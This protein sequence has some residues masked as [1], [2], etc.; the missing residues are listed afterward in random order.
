MTRERPAASSA[1]RASGCATALYAFAASPSSRR[2]HII[3]CFSSWR[4]LSLNLRICTSIF[5]IRIMAATMEHRHVPVGI[6]PHAHRGS[7]CLVRLLAGSHLADALTDAPYAVD[8][9]DG[10][11]KCLPHAYIEGLLARVAE[12]TVD[13]RTNALAFGTSRLGVEKLIDLEQRLVANSVSFAQCATAT[14]IRRL[15]AE[16]ARAPSGEYQVSSS[17]YEDT[18]PF[19]GNEGANDTWLSRIQ[20]GELTDISGRLSVYGDLALLCGARSTIDSRLL[21]GGSRFAYSLVAVA[22]ATCVADVGLAAPAAIPHQPGVAAV[23]AVYGRGRG[24]RGRGRGPLLAAAIPAHAAVPAAP[25]PSS[26]AD[27]DILS[28]VADWLRT[29]SLPS[30]LVSLP[31]SIR[32]VRLE[33]QAR[34]A[35][36]D[37]SRR[38]TIVRSRFAS[39]LPCVPNLERIVAGATA[40]TQIEVAQQLAF[41]ICSTPLVPKSVS[42]FHALDDALQPFMFVLAQHGGVMSVDARVRAVVAAHEASAQRRRSAPT[43]SAAA[44]AT[45][46]GSSG[47]GGKGIPH[48][49]TKMN[50]DSMQEYISKHD[51]AFMQLVNT[52]ESSKHTL[53]PL[54]ANDSV[55]ILRVS[56]KPQWGVAFLQFNQSEVPHNA[57]MFRTVEP[58]RHK[59]YEYISNVVF[60]NADGGLDRVVEGDLLNHTFV[61][62]FL[63]GKNWDTA[64]YYKFLRTPEKLARR[65]VDKEFLDESWPSGVF[66]SKVLLRSLLRP[67]DQL[68]HAIGYRARSRTGLHGSLDLLVHYLET[69]DDK[70]DNPWEELYS[71]FQAFMRDAQGFHLSALKSTASAS[72]P[73]FRTDNPSWTARVNELTDSAMRR[74]TDDRRRGTYHKPPAAAGFNRNVNFGNVVNLADATPDFRRSILKDD[75]KRPASPTS[76]TGSQYWMPDGGSSLSPGVWGQKTKVGEWAPRVLKLDASTMVIAFPSK[77]GDQKWEYNVPLCRRWLKR[78]EG[79]DNKCLACAVVRHPGNR[80]AFCPYA[81]T[82]GHESEKSSAHTFTSEPWNEFGKYGAGYAKKLE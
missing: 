41:S 70:A 39:L 24:G 22:R 51:N 68:F 23:P 40:S 80:C 47:T 60:Q 10:S 72:F 35:F 31:L 44:V 56:Y 59:L 43:A 58:H 5:I 19:A 45:A 67:L 49:F 36:A 18:Q 13:V 65:V 15:A 2:S 53:S 14:M 54:A 77:R 3:A 32:D 1:P 76:S 7:E 57:L 21:S 25:F 30:E 34:Q 37:D 8:P 4:T 82:P 17:D 62:E 27:N 48:A 26:A 28:S 38:E 79:T 20:I 66:S 29:Y 74:A 55:R 6:D 71:I 52:V 78:N 73:I 9:D 42:S 16:A 33:I 75:R 63:A 46:S 50:H 81:G 64:N 12:P 61:D 11:T 69:Y